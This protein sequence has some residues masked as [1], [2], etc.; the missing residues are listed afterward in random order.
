MKRTSLAAAAVL[1]IGLLAP[2]AS[3]MASSDHSSPNSISASDHGKKKG[4]VHKKATKFV[5]AGTVTAVADG[6][7]TFTV[8][9]GKNKALR[10]MPLTVAVTADTKVTRNDAPAGATNLVTVGDHVNVKYTKSGDTN[11][12]SRVSAESPDFDAEG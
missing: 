9:G 8:H 3:A 5:N 11:V 1:A 6:S 2:T 12:A 4:H 7:I 10:G